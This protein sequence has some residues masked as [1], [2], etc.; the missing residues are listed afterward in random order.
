MVQ[1]VTATDCGVACLTMVLN[2]HGQALRL[3]E[4]REVV[5]SDRD[6]V[7]AR[8]LLNADTWF[9][10]HGRAVSLE[11]ED[12]HF[13]PRGAVLHWKFRHFVVLD[14][15]GAR[16]VDIVDPAVGHRRV[17]MPEFSKCFTGVALLFEPSPAFR[18]SGSRARPSAQLLAGL[19]RQHRGLVARIIAASLFLQLLGLAL[20]ALVTAVIDRVVPLGDRHLLAVLGGALLGLTLFTFLT[21]A[22]PAP[23]HLPRCEPGHDLHRAPPAP[24]IPVLSPARARRLAAADRQQRRD[25][26]A[27]DRGG[28]VGGAR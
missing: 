28:A 26:R 6:G 10:L 19:L 11:L 18:R 20:P 4:V 13:L 1:Q 17:P 8:S 2:Y 7:D 14:R 15:V 25:P 9:G 5:S 21:T 3:T 12:L 27:R 23:A 16:S 22:A 24:A